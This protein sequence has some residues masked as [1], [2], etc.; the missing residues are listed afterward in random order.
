MTKTRT[1]QKTKQTIWFNPD[2]LKSLLIL[3]ILCSDIYI[4]NRNK[5]VFLYVGFMLWPKLQ[6]RFKSD[7]GRQVTSLRI[8]SF[9]Q[10]LN[11]RSF[12]YCSI[13]PNKVTASNVMCVQSSYDTINEL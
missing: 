10:T 12:V 9:S 5:A 4:V 3:Q 2:S 1:Y 13:T 7:G 6:I 8:V 11:I